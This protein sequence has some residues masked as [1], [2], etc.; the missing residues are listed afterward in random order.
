[1]NTSTQQTEA[2]QV[3][4][5]YSTVKQFCQRHPA[6][7]QGGMRHLIF[8]E[9]K[10]GLAKSGAIVRIGGSVKINENKFFVWVEAQG[11]GA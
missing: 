6:F 11:T 4:W 1:M 2:I 7:T 8:N 10:N 9:S 5:I 3:L